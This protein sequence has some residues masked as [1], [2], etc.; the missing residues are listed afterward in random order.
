MNIAHD[1]DGQPF[2]TPSGKLEFYSEQLAK[3]GMPPMPDWEPRSDRGRGLRSSRAAALTARGLLR[4]P[5]RLLRRRV[6][7]QP[8]RQAL[9]HPA[10]RGRRRSAASRMATRYALFNDRGEIGLML[11]VADEVQLGVL[12]VPGQRPVGESVSAHDQHA[13]FGPH[14]PTWVKAR[15]IRAPGS[16]SLLEGRGGGLSRAPPIDH[17]SSRTS[18]SS[19]SPLL[20]ARNG[21][22]SGYR[23][24]PRGY[25]PRA[26]GT[27]RHRACPAGARPRSGWSATPPPRH[28][29]APSESSNCQ[30]RS[31]A[32]ARTK[33]VSRPNSLARHG[34]VVERRLQH[35]V[36][37]PQ[38]QKSLAVARGPRSGEAGHELLN[39]L[40]GH[41]RLPLLLEE[42]ARR[43]QPAESGGVRTLR[44]F[45][46]SY[47]PDRTKRCWVRSRLASFGSA[48]AHDQR[49]EVRR[50]PGGRRSLPR[51]GTP[52]RRRTSRAPDRAMDLEGVHPGARAGPAAGIR[53]RSPRRRRPPE[54]LA[55]QN[56]VTTSPSF[57]ECRSTMWFS[58]GCWWESVLGPQ[59]VPS[60][61]P[62][63]K[64]P[65]RLFHC[66]LLHHLRRRDPDAAGAAP[67]RACRSPHP[68]CLA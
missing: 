36:G 46:R 39:I 1:W 60:F 8:R 22:V 65:C 61:R 12:L 56:A 38:R 50:F 68:V 13:L 48:S 43:R 4:G 26:G 59:T 51:R 34:R 57:G 18:G 45:F 35:P 5:H 6:P 33:S 16:R 31:G 14:A 21:A 41:R 28:R 52:R 64:R 30:T 9:L 10:S 3:Q 47:V 25:V 67:C 55:S 29:R 24:A 62:A 66:R 49:L 2:K 42:D 15:P 44:L 19:G 58:R 63:S 11:K 40:V 27:C 37:M 7:A 20:S 54:G 32:A 23:R 17:Q 53:G